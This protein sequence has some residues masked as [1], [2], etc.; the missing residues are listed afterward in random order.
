MALVT[1]M[2]GFHNCKSQFR[3]DIGLHNRTSS[4]QGMPT[5]VTLCIR[6]K[7]VAIS[8]ALDAYNSVENGVIVRV[9]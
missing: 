6:V 5:I 8:A 4:Q 9:I 3:Y 7:G 1:N 2:L